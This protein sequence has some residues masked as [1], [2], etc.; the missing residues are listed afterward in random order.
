MRRGRFIRGIGETGDDSSSV[1]P[2]RR[3]L[4]LGAGLAGGAA[5]LGD[6]NAQEVSKG[7]DLSKTGSATKQDGSRAE[8]AGGTEGHDYE[9]DGTR[10]TQPF[11]GTRQSG[12]VTPQPAAAI[13]VAFNVLASDRADLQRLFRTLTAR[14]AFLTKGGTSASR[15]PRM[16]PLDSGILGPEILPDNL[17]MTVALGASLFDKR[18][19]L[20]DLKPK[21]LTAMERF[22]NDALDA[23]FCHGDVLIQFCANTAE[24]NLHALRD[25][26]KNTPDLLEIRWQLNGFLPPNT[27]KKLGKDT[28]RNLMGFKDGT[29]NIDAQ[30]K[31]LMDE[32][33]WVQQKAGE[34]VWA[35]GGTYQVVR[36]IRMTVERWD[37]TP[38]GEQE[39]IFGRHKMSGAPIGKTQ[40]H[41]L[42]GYAENP[43]SETIATDAHIR[44]ANPRTP[45]TRKNLILRRGYNYSREISK[46]GQLD[47]G[48]AFVCFQSDLDAGFRT[49]Q[50]RLNGE[51][52]EEYIKPFGGGFFFVPPGARD[53]TDYLA[54][55]LVEHGPA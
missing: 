14:I 35:R 17:T 45:E 6:A 21:A 44:L 51:R 22:P 2:S 42:P 55:A 27:L 15:N 52:L 43:K 30:D 1:T 31:R 10:E 12:V 37:R 40:E 29:A 28:I 23:D 33:V 7:T 48:L 38:L 19:D 46:S 3:A 4:I 25:I 50:A 11:Y 5:I 49:V 41:D 39:S 34:P 32:L 9:S 13:L 16:P 47:M 20:A 26:V 8:R 36:L 53:E 24:T 18:F 54:K